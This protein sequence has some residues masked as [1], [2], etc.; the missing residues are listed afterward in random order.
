MLSDM[1]VLGD[2]KVLEHWLQMDSL[3]PDSL[4]VLLKYLLDKRKLLLSDIKVL[5]PS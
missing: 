5:S 1:L 2:I 4:P 3:D